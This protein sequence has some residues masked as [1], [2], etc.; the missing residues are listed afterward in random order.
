MKQVDFQES[1]HDFRILSASVIESVVSSWVASDPAIIYHGS[2]I[3]A[4]IPCIY[5]KLVSIATNKA[6]AAYLVVT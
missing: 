6:G 2:I 3:W 4:Y 1:F 5:L